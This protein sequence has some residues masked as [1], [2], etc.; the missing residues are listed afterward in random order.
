[1]TVKRENKFLN[2]LKTDEELIRDKIVAEMD[3]A[4]FLEASKWMS[5]EEII[6]RAASKATTANYKACVLKSATKGQYN[7]SI[8]YGEAGSAIA[9]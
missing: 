8:P 7:G 1:M 2:N 4:E 9:V 3:S 6:A 5:S